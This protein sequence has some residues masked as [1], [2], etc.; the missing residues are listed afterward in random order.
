MIGLR[1]LASGSYSIAAISKMATLS[2]SFERMVGGGEGPQDNHDI[3]LHEDGNAQD[4]EG[5]G[6]ERKFNHF[7]TPNSI[8]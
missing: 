1:T 7:F 2:D 5:D 3:T 4:T 8:D 6:F